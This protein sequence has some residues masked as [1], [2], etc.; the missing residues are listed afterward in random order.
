MDGF[1]VRITKSGI[2]VL[3]LHHTADPD[4]RPGTPEGDLWLDRTSAGY[5][6][7]TRGPRWRKEMDIDYGALGGTKVFPDMEKYI[8]DG[9]IIIP[10]FAPE[11]GKIYG[12]YDHGWRHAA[13]Y[14]LHSIN[15]DGDIVTFWEFYGERVTV[16]EIAKI[17]NGQSI[18][19]SE[20]KR[21]EGSPYAGREVFKIADPQI[22]AEDQQMSDNPMKSISHLFETAYP[23]VYFEPGD[24]GGDTTVIEWIMGYFWKDPKK[25]KWRITKTC[26]K[27]IWELGKLRHRE[28]SSRVALNREQPEQLVDKDN[29]AWDDVKM[30][31]KRFPPTPSEMQAAKK[32]GSFDWWKKQAQNVEEGGVAASYRREM[33]S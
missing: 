19:T 3:R 20:G 6:G 25:P 27:L 4:K 12:S 30:F 21:F 22:W 28:F 23:P 31:L 29:H 11:G 1:K 15:Y 13:S 32:P 2:P 18:T 33:I 16:S 10:S 9:V 7:G 8:S 17:I 14:H 5:P 24:R 26:P